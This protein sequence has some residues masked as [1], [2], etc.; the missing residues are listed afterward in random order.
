MIMRI[1]PTGGL[2]KRSIGN[3]LVATWNQS[4]PGSCGNGIGAGGTGSGTALAKKKGNWRGK[5]WMRSKT[6]AS[7]ETAAYLR[8]SVQRRFRKGSDGVWGTDVEESFAECFA[9]AKADPQALKRIYPPLADW[10]ADAEHLRPLLPLLPRRKL[11]HR[12]L[13]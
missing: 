10:F 11:R 3:A 8:H 12:I 6:G 4:I 7:K 1:K 9:L 13:M 2:T 5:H